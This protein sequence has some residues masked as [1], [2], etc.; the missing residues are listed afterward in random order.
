MEGEQSYSEVE[1][2]HYFEPMIDDIVLF[3]HSN[4][5]EVALGKS[6]FVYIFSYLSLV[7]IDTI[8][9]KVEL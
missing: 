3:V 8:Y 2:L 4:L 9:Y 5:E 7:L 1:R 6:L